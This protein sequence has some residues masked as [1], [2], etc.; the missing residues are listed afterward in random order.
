MS[1]GLMGASFDASAEARQERGNSITNAF[2]NVLTKKTDN[3]D[4]L[5]D[6][7]PDSTASRAE[8]N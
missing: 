1:K 4:N 8:S 5:E 6:Q 7:S 2:L 3:D